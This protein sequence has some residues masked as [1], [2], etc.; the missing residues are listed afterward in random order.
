VP[1][2]RASSRAASRFA[3]LSLLVLRRALEDLRGWPGLLV[4]TTNP[5][6]KSTVRPG[7]IGEAAGYASTARQQVEHLRWWA[8]STSSSSNTA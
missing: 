5:V 1:A 8:F 4:I 3:S 7:E 6:A 2:P